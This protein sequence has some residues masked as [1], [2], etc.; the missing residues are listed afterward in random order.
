MLN[1]IV[2][3]GRFTRDCE[4]RYTNN[5]KAVVSFTL[6]VDRP[7]RDKG[8]VY[9]NC[10]AWEHTATFIEKYFRKGDM[11]LVQGSLQSRNYE[12]RD[13]NKRTA[14]E[15]IVREA[16]FCGSKSKQEEPSYSRPQRFQELNDADSDLPF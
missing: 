13:G 14:F 6:A 12:D 5:Q 10:V 1:S 2:L 4:M 11:I 15:V 16:N 8:A 3:Q 7:G 9:I